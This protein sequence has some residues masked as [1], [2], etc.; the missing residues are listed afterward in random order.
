M[1]A[2]PAPPAS[3]DRFVGATLAERYRLLD[4]IGQGGAG[5]VYRAVQ[6]PMGRE[7]AVKIMHGLPNPEEAHDI[8]VRFLREAAL[9]GRIQ[10][11]NVVTLHDFGRTPEGDCYIVMEHLRGRTLRSLMREGALP[12]PRALRIHEQ[13]LSGLRAVHSA[14]MVHRDIKPSNIILLKADDG[15]DFVKIF[16]FG[17]VKGDDEVTISQNG[18]FMGTP[19]YVSPEQARGLDA[20][21]RA[22][23]Y[24]AGVV[25]YRLLTGM[26]PFYADNPLSVAAM[27]I[28]DPVPPM[29]E[30]APD[31]EVPPAVEAMVRRL[32]E[33]DPA[34]R[35]ANAEEA[36]VELARVRVE[37]GLPDEGP[38]KTTP[39]LSTPSLATSPGFEPLPLPTRQTGRLAMGLGAL[40]L[41]GAVGIGTAAIVRSPGPAP[42]EPHAPV[43]VAESVATE[44]VPPPPPPREV[45]LL[46][47][48]EPGGA[49]VRWGEVLLGTTPLARGVSVLEGEGG[50]QAFTLSLSGHRPTTVELDLD[51]DQATG[52]AVL[53]RVAG[54][55]TASGTSANRPATPAAA[56]SEAASTRPSRSV[57]IDEVVFEPAEAEDALRWLNGA[58]EAAL[59][60][61]G[62]APRQANIILEGRPFDSLH[63]FGDTPY[64]GTKTVESVRARVA[65]GAPSP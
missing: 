52:H 54:R 28:R 1:P 38:P 14:G 62:I 64:I 42:V 31:V 6:E 55:E 58:D 17:L 30:M 32:L 60:S 7:V 46:I 10:H 19:H 48:S 63:A 61:S 9:A 34:D 49:E 57:V 20:D 43:V 24:S 29:V 5:R 45:V 18:V 4:L 26:L 53:A 27:H 51:L 41:V 16:D 2:M 65:S 15:G 23:L 59:R 25:L 37:L 47:S 35:P 13:L 21:Q 40:L 8:E 22:D 56:A 44:V 50:P 36:L 33:K 39:P 3:T 11:P 12:V